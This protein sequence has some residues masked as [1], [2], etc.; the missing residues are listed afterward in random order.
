MQR[1][2]ERVRE[3]ALR[4]DA[5]P[6]RWL[7]GLDDRVQN[8]GEICRVVMHS[9]NIVVHV[10]GALPG[11]RSVVMSNHLS[12]LDPL[13]ISAFVPA[14]PIAKSEVEAWP[15]V[16]PAAQRFGVLFTQRTRPEQGA[17]VLRC[18]LRALDRGVSILNFPEGTT[19][20]GET[21][22]PLKRGLF[23]IARRAQAPVVP[24]VL[25]FEDRAMCWVGDQGFIPHYAG[26]LR[27]EQ[28][29][30][31][32]AFGDPIPPQNFDSPEALRDATRNA[33]MALRRSHFGER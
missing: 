15:I 29:V 18:C 10:S 33:M 24:T 2:L 1:T 19:S 5:L 16:G 17:T 26:L 7:D 28:T 6:E 4:S 12:Y 31:H 11:S 9:H 8:F 27:R 23:G 21:V 20:F 14:V 22:L 13:I 30:T 25:R 3:T 32:L